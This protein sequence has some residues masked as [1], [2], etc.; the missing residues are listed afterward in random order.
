MTRIIGLMLLAGLLAACS[1]DPDSS[2]KALPVKG[3]AM[4]IFKMGTLDGKLVD[5]HNLFAGKVII[6]NVWATWCPPCRKEMPDLIRLSRL[7]PAN[8]F[9]VVGLAA[10][11]QAEDVRKFIEEKHVS[12]PIYWDK[13]GKQLAGPQLGVFK[14]PET[15][16]INRRG[17]YLEK[18]MGG[19]PWA[20]PITVRI[21]NTIYNTGKIPEQSSAGTPG[22]R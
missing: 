13:G 4:P 3:Q 7:L 15:F 9:I 6:L 22:A 18:I 14:Y 19:F 8:K 11:N 12:F 21:L 17:V 20:S 16:I 2:G 10:D 5:S 1:V